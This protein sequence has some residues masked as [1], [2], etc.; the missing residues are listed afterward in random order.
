MLFAALRV[1][2]KDAS[3]LEREQRKRMQDQRIR[4]GGGGGG[5][6]SSSSGGGGGDGGNAMG[7]AKQSVANPVVAA[8][9]R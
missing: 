2:S 6:M 3:A 1:A 8:G 4:G 9:R 7:F 5:A